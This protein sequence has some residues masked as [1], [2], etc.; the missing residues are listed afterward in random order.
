MTDGSSQ[1]AYIT[2]CSD[3]VIMQVIRVYFYGYLMAQ[4]DPQKSISS[5]THASLLSTAI[6]NARIAIAILP[7]SRDVGQ[8]LTAIRNAGKSID[9]YVAQTPCDSYASNATA[10]LKTLVSVTSI[11]CKRGELGTST[12]RLGLPKRTTFELLNQATVAAL[13]DFVEAPRLPR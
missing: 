3:V 12:S 5:N 7:H 8:R 4:I 10:L 9:S 2:R 6:D 1:T 13:R 11:A